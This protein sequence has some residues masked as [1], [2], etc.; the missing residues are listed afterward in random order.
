MS[1]LGQCYWIS[2]RHTLWFLLRIIISMRRKASIL[3]RGVV[4]PAIVLLTL[5]NSIEALPSTRLRAPKLINRRAA[6]GL[7]AAALTAPVQSVCAI[8]TGDVERDMSKSASRETR[9][10]YKDNLGVKS[11]SSVQRAWESSEGKTTT[12]IMMAARGA[13][14]RDPDA[15]P[16]SER[17]R[18]RRAM[19]GCHE[20][21]YRKLAG[22]IESEAACNSRVLGG[23][24]Q[25]MLTVLDAN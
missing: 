17:S 1:G 18:K 2:L 3:M 21:A 12:E 19:A 6:C 5:A 11:Y 4:G 7:V 23:E 16:E 10:G 13:I 22:A 9:L 20:E 15:P 8:T 24:V 14:K 25:F